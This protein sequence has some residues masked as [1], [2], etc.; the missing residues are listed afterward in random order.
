M[1]DI[2]PSTIGGSLRYD[3][4]MDPELRSGLA[5]FEALGLAEQELN[6]EA[7]LALRSRAKELSV[8]ARAEISANNRVTRED[9]VVPG[10][11]SASEVRIR[12]YRPIDATA[13]MPCLYWIHGGGMIIGD[14]E[15]DDLVCEAYAE[16]VRCVVV[17]VEYRL[18]PEH[19]YPAQV[20]DCYAGLCWTAGAASELGVDPDRIAVGGASAG[21]GLAA[22]TVLLARDRGGPALAFQLLI[23]PMLDDRNSTASAVEFAGILS[24]SRDHNRSGWA[25]LLGERAASGDVPAYAAPARAGDLSKLPPTLIQVGELEVFR[26]ENI[27]YAARLLQAGVATELHVYPGAY[28]GWDQVAP[29]ADASMRMIDERI[30]ALRRALGT[31]RSSHETVRSPADREIIPG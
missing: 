3:D 29:T 31:A 9:R 23:Y 11:D 4:N 28:H 19:P 24:W 16:R 21:G 27:Q 20:N 1:L 6:P 18:A 26:D 17:S 7:I 2:V 15:S 5:E 14:V 12:I 13:A 25:A 30:C 10:L 8:A 22:A